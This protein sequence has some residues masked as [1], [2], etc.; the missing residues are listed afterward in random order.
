MIGSA[1]FS[2]SGLT[3]ANAGPATLITWIIGGIILLFYGMQ[4]AELCTIYPK[5]GGIFVFPYEVLGKD[6]RSKEVWGWTA[7]WAF[8]NINIFGAAFSAI[9]IATYL[10]QA[11]PFFEGKVI[12]CAILFIL[13][14]GVLCLFNIAVAGRVNLV[15]VLGLI[16]ILLILVFSSISFWDMNNFTPFFTRGAQGASGFISQIPT[17]MLA[18]G[19]IISVAFMITQV[20]N[21]KKT[22]PHSMIIAMGATIFL[23]VIVIVSIIG[24]LS[25]EAFYTDPTMT[26]IQFV[27][28][29]AA[30]WFV[31]GHITWL[32]ALISIGATLALTTTLL[33]LLMIAS[34]TIQAAASYGLLPKGLAKVHPKKGAPTNAVIACTLTILGLA[35]IP[36]ITEVLVNSGAICSALCVVIIAFTLLRARKQHEYIPGNFRVPGGSL[37]PLFS[38]VVVLIFIL[39]G[40]FQQWLYWGMVLA[41]FVVGAIVFFICRSANKQAS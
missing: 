37:I 10:T 28:L 7:A 22:V 41:W 30:A 12:P 36:N 11:F 1:I 5:S 35:C 8:L 3:Y 6:K 4:T 33:V 39:P 18:Y 21:P 38:A 40:V 9:Y 16:I 19:A 20:K 27:P 15:L 29:Y 13:A 26:W 14:C 17:A 32:P 24:L 25:A 31:L 23:Y 2:L 34:W